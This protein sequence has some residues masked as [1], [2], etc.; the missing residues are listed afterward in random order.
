MK[1]IILAGLCLLSYSVSI[2]AQHC[3]TVY[4]DSG[5]ILGDAHVS[6]QY[7]IPIEKN[8][9]GQYCIERDMDITFTISH[10]GFE[11]KT[12]H[13][14][15]V[16]ALSD[17]GIQLNPIAQ[18]LV[19]FEVNADRSSLFHPRSLVS[20]ARISPVIF[21]RSQSVNLAEGLGFSPA[22]RVE[23][24]C[25]NCGFTQ[26]RM[27]GLPGAYTQIVLNG[28]P[29][30]SA[31][32]GVY[33]LEFIPAA[34]IGSVEVLRGGGS[35]LYGGNAIAGIV[36]IRTKSP[37][38][39][40]VE[41]GFQYTL[42][43]NESP[44]RLYHFGTSRVSEQGNLGFRMDY[45]HRNRE[46]FDAD[47]D[48]FTEI[49][50]LDQNVL[51]AQ[52]FWKPGDQSRLGFDMIYVDEFRRGGSELHRPPHAS[53]IAEQLAHNLSTF[54]LTYEIYSRDLL[55]K[56]TIYASGQNTIRDS[57]YGV[58]GRPLNATDTIDESLSL[59]LNAYG[60]T[61]DRLWLG[62]AQY[63]RQFSTDFDINTGIELRSNAI[64]DDMTG[65]GRNIDQHTFSA[66]LYTQATYQVSKGFSLSAGGRYERSQ[67]N[68]DYTF[69]GNLSYES[70]KDFNNLVGRLLAKYT[71]NES[72]SLKGSYAGGFRLPQAFDEDLHIEAVGGAPRFVLLPADLKSENSHSYVGE[73]LWEGKANWQLNVS[74]FYTLI[75]NPFINADARELE[76]GISVVEK[77]NGGSA[78]VSGLSVDGQYAP[79]RHLSLSG[80]VTWQVAAFRN[81]EI[82]WDSDE[83]HPAVTT[84]D[85]LR[86]PDWYGSLIA[87]Y[88]L[89]NWSLSLSGLFTGR[90]TVMRLIDLDTEE[91]ALIRTPTFA[92]L[93]AKISRKLVS[94]N[95][96]EVHLYV[97][98]YNFL[99]SYQDDFDQGINRDAGYVYGPMRP[100]SFYGGLR[101]S[102]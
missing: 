53:Q 48:G 62:G 96:Q 44:D 64:H 34:S 26:V 36:N 42:T 16:V 33:G 39:N 85:M 59:A 83:G 38:E 88:T 7:G 18:E 92:D 50:R 100:R 76:S 15:D 77:R 78:F 69:P 52:A 65:Y 14:S 84:R 73:I 82:L 58:G 25:Q 21:E 102:W 68:A 41:G 35:A 46:G 54:G 97:G 31:L 99:N 27:N 81:D 1:H 40:A 43:G 37:E 23:N 49:T 67:I 87:D 55:S 95:G 13:A 10:I 5:E 8:K 20:I 93:G 11:S 56:T 72:I 3:F 17:A 79:F 63:A 61:R 71:I 6:D 75:H 4:N 89:Q 86:T 30:F 22:L 90:M 91:P 29:V 45:S 9:T 74:G 80:N 94:K 47:S 19:A 98:C 32:T 57:Y 66:A 60:Q 51:T 28:R 2:K 24:N 70:M 101:F 12:F